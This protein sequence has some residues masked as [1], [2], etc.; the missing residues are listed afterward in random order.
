MNK[1]TQAKALL[2]EILQEK[3]LETLESQGKLLHELAVVK[4]LDIS[5]K[6]F[7]LLQK[8]LA[9]NPEISKENQDFDVLVKVSLQANMNSSKYQEAQRCFARVQEKFEN[10]EFKLITEAE[11]DEAKGVILNKFT[12]SPSDLHTVDKV[13]Y[14][15]ILRTFMVNNAILSGLFHDGAVIDIKELEKINPR[16]AHHAKKT[17]LDQF[18]LINYGSHDDAYEKTSYIAYKVSSDENIQ[19]LLTTKM[20]NKES[21][22]CYA[23]L[24][25]MAVPEFQRYATLTNGKDGNIYSLEDFAHFYEEFKI[26]CEIAGKQVKVAI[27]IWHGTIAGEKI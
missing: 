23:N 19:H 6:I 10:Q 24:N 9:E 12:T 4:S 3:T 18:C 22:I 14:R 2:E 11:L 8:A 27:P 16:A 20:K 13:L 5:N 17:A 26:N 15:E 7:P 1:I 21:V 25:P